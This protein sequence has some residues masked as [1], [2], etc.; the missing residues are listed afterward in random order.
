M[1]ALNNNDF[2]LE[3]EVIVFLCVTVCVFDQA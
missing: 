3:M 2:F 1:D